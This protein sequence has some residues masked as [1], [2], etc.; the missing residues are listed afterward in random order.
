[1]NKEIIV[2]ECLS[3]SEICKKEVGGGGICCYWEGS[4]GVCFDY[5]KKVLPLLLDAVRKEKG[6]EKMGLPLKIEIYNSKLEYYMKK[7]LKK[8]S[9]YT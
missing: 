4:G 5:P 6:C 2:T 8:T 7:V 1:M 3:F 9:E